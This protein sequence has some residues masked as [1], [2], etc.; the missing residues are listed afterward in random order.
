MIAKVSQAQELMFDTIGAKTP[1]TTDA[2]MLPRRSI[3]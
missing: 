1:H 2:V 3:E